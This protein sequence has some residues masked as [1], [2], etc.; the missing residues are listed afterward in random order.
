MSNYFYRE[1]NNY[2]DARKETKWMDDY[3]TKYRDEKAYQR[4]KHMPNY[5]IGLGGSICRG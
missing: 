2:R 1:A 4:F 3:L 5:N